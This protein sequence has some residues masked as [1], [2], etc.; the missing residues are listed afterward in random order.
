MRTG[1]MAAL[2]SCAFVSGCA[3]MPKLSGDGLPLGRTGWQLTGGVD[4]ESGA[5]WV[6]FCKPFGAKER[7]IAD[8]FSK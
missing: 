5:Y 8:S 6:L 7:T 1:L 4:F 3:S 2:L